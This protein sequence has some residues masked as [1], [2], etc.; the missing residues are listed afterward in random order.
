ML[1]CTQYTLYVDFSNQGVKGRRNVLQ[2]QLSL[3]KR[4][5][6]NTTGF[7]LRYALLFK[8][9]VNVKCQQIFVS[10]QT[11][12]IKSYAEIIIM[13][14]L[15]ISKIMNTNRSTMKCKL[16]TGKLFNPQDN[17]KITRQKVIQVHYG[18]IEECNV[19]IV[20]I[21]TIGSDTL[22]HWLVL[23]ASGKS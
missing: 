17:I 2:F 13:S 10:L 14:T 23:T 4:V 22:S 12:Y 9:E 20:L 11:I 16:A 5:G 19:E 8:T 6:F 21:L 7:Y 1:R 15:G 18:N 3:N